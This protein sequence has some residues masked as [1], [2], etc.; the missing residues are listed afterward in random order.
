MI[1]I[2]MLFCTFIFLRFIAV[3]ICYDHNVSSVKLLYITLRE[4][5]WQLSF[6]NRLLGAIDSDY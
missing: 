2:F 6:E 5:T 1:Y 3:A 4:R